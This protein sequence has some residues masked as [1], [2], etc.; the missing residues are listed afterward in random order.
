MI[1]NDYKQDFAEESYLVAF[2]SPFV[3]GARGRGTGCDQ[4]VDLPHAI[5]KRSIASCS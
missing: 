5:R 4:T 1:T 2:L 3:Y